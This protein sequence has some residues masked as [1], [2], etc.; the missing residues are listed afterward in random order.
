[1]I[2]ISKRLKYVILEASISI[3]LC[4]SS[5]SNKFDGFGKFKKIGRVK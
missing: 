3:I 4:Q 5:I 1:M 2:E